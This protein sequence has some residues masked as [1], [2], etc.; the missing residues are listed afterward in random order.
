M[1]K[2]KLLESDKRRIELETE[3]EQLKVQNAT[4]HEALEHVSQHGVYTKKIISAL[5]SNAAK[6]YHN[7]ADVEALRD[8]KSALWQS[9]CMC[10]S[11]RICQRCDAIAA[12]DKQIGGGQDEV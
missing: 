4:M 1:L 8:A 3:N 12:I 11:D 10:L 2:R 6:D 5:A 9:G 7:P